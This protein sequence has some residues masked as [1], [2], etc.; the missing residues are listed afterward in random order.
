[1]VGHEDGFYKPLKIKFT[2]Q[3]RPAKTK[4]D[5]LYK[6]LNMNTGYTDPYNN[7]VV[8]TL[9]ISEQGKCGNETIMVGRKAVPNY[10]VVTIYS[11][12]DSTHYHL[13]LKT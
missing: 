12:Y 9:V 2:C 4:A 1:M 13:Q 10:I 6:T 5:I 8:I 11:N 7:T 3:T